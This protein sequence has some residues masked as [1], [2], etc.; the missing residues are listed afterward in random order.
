MGW[1]RVPLGLALLVAA[2]LGLARLL[3]PAATGRR[4]PLSH[5]WWAAVLAG[6]GAAVALGS[7]SLTVIALAAAADAGALPLA[8]AWAAV[9]GANVGATALP[10]ALG[11]RLPP[12]GV[13]ALAL[14][15]AAACAFRPLRRV[16]GVA[17]TLTVMTAGMALL[18]T[19][20]RGLAPEALLARVAL[21]QVPAAFT[22]GVV[23]TAL[24]FSSQLAVGIVQALAQ[25]GAMPLA[26]GIA[27]V[28]G[29]NIGTTADVLL[30]GLG[31]GWRG[32]HTVLFHLV[33]NIVAAALGLAALGPLVRWLGAAPPATALARAHSLLNVTL[34]L[35]AGPLT[36]PLARCLAP[37]PPA[38]FR[39]GGPDCARGPRGSP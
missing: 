26:A 6:A 3:R 16:A 4:W 13:V 36:A 8:T 35:I 39:E 31:C 19:G 32:R 10:H 7:S 30:A 22:A 38:R 21:D 2:T 17:L 5:A 27:F 34:A 28:C 25:G 14:A 33:F 37:E 9:A 29:A 20:V 18:A 24:L 15:A 1:V 23:V 12:G 11:V